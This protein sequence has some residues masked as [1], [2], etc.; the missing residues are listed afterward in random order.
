MMDNVLHFDGK[1]SPICV[2]SIELT[3][4]RS[5][6]AFW[7]Q[8]NI[9]AENGTCKTT[10]SKNNTRVCFEVLWLRVLC[11]IDV[12]P[13]LPLSKLMNSDV[14]YSNGC[15]FPQNTI[16]ESA[17]TQNIGYLATM[18]TYRLG[19]SF[20]VNLFVHKCLNW[21]SAFRLFHTFHKAALG[22]TMFELATYYKSFFHTPRSYKMISIT[23][24]YMHQVC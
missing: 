19:Q 4:R 6:R 13:T 11:C 5:F 21:K 20:C 17:T 15:H 22:T 9:M 8:N 23:C 10:L 18:D 1:T 14:K 2:I 3:S 12:L 16:R 24:V 7:V